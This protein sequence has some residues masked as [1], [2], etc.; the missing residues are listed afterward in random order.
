MQQRTIALVGVIALIALAGCSASAPNP[1]PFEERSS[2]VQNVTEAE[3]EAQVVLTLTESVQY[4]EQV[5]DYNPALGMV[6][7][8]P[9]WYPTD[10]TSVTL[11]HNG[12]V[13]DTFSDD[14]NYEGAAVT[15]ATDEPG[16]YGV[17]LDLKSG[18][19]VTI[20][21]NKTASGNVTDYR[22]PR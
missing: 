3:D 6:T 21:F 9:Q 4:S 11:T 12:S 8:D 7:C 2:L 20:A 1:E 16:T 14:A 13:T 22:A 5:C 10:I 17:Q 18:D 15:V 19:D